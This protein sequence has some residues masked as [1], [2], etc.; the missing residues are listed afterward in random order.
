MSRLLGRTPSWLS[1]FKR[2]IMIL[3]VIG[4]CL[5]ITGVE[6]LVL[7]GRNTCHPPIFV[8]LLFES[9]SWEMRSLM[10][11]IRRT[12]VV[13]P[14]LTLGAMNR[15]SIENKIYRKSF[16]RWPSTGVWFKE[17][18]GKVGCCGDLFSFKS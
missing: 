18:R 12:E 3:I 17:R 16:Q 5:D 13:S 15:E 14:V 8:P 4:K 7:S 10:C 9:Q 11:K 1:N 2:P 6:V